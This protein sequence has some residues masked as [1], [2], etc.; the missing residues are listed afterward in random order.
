M[1]A[2]A[3][4]EPVGTALA[5]ILVVSLALHVRLYRELGRLRSRLDALTPPSLDAL[6]NVAR[7]ATADANRALVRVDELARRYDGLQADLQA[8]I[9]RVGVVRFNPFRDTG[10][11]QSFAVALL[12]ELGNGVVLSGLHNRSDTRVF[13][14]PVRDG[15][16]T[17]T[18]SREEQ[19]AIAQANGLMAPAGGSP[20][21]RTAPTGSPS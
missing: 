12:D 11:D 1:I 8:T 10:G 13:A 3:K 17:Y 19:Q 6:S 5:V 15:T 2:L 18:L 20:R 14:K 4:A 7:A 9:Q 21:A 16:S